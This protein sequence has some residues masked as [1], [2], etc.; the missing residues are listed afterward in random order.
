MSNNRFDRQ[1]SFFGEEGQARIRNLRVAIVGLGG[2]GSHVAQQLAFLGVRHFALLDY[3]VAA[4]ANLNR[5][6]GARRDDVISA[7]LKVDI[8]ERVIKEIERD[9]TVT[10]VSTGLLSEAGFASIQ[11]ADV[12]FGCMDRETPRL[13][14]NELCQAYEIPYIDLAT[15]IDV[16]N[17]SNFGGRIVVSIDGERCLFCAGAIDQLELRREQLSA[18]QR[19]EED[20]IYGVRRQDLGNSGPSV[21]SLNGL[22]ASAAVTEFLVHWTGIRSAKRQLEYRGAFGVLAIITTPPSPGC[23]YCANPEIRGQRERAN[24][25]RWL[26]TAAADK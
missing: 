9:A 19:T 5:L 23:P 3:D 10:R 4:E 2:T 15:E 25:E 14:L 24:V 7:R 18:E 26:A 21:V 16:E 6:I 11:Q 12:V 17:P 22:L 13:V 1:I 20:R 8:A